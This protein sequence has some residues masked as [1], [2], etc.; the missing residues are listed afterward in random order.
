MADSLL[1]RVVAPHRPLLAL[2]L[3]ASLLYLPSVWMRDLWNPD[4]PRYAEVAREM[5]ARD[6]YALPH[7]NGAV[8]GEK[9]P[10]FFWLGAA[11][12]SLPGVPFESGTRLVSAL[13]A[14]G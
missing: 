12:G 2:T 9:P 8:Y 10:L 1:A 3:L 13:A 7:L 6:D 4:E 14:L 11:A 5:V